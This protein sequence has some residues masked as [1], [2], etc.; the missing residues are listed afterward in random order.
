MASEKEKKQ[1]GRIEKGPLYAR[2][3]S[4]KKKIDYGVYIEPVVFK[5]MKTYRDSNGNDRDREWY[6]V[7]LLIS[8]V[9]NLQITPNIGKLG[10]GTGSI[11]YRAD[12][13]S[14]FERD[15]KTSIGPIKQKKKKKKSKPAPP[16]VKKFVKYTVSVKFLEVNFSDDAMTLNN[17]QRFFGSGNSV[18][19]AEMPTIKNN[20]VMLR[21]QCQDFIHTWGRVSSQALEIPSMWKRAIPVNA[22]IIPGMSGGAVLDSNGNLR[23]IN[24]GT[25]TAVVGMTPFGPQTSFTG[26]AYFVS[27]S[28]ICFLLGR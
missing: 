15:E 27:S 4:F 21:C 3:G 2:R 8:G 9:S 22:T 19:Y 16:V 6:N 1:T 7:P 18:N 12:V 20:K 17:P 5:E 25:L 10:E 28:D 23:G 14:E 26:I 24:V 11:L 13:K